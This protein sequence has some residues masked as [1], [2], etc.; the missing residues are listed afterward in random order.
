MTSSAEAENGVSR[1]EDKRTTG[2]GILVVLGG[3]LIHM[4]I[5]TNSSYTF[6]QLGP[7]VT[8][9]IRERSQPED[10]TSQDL[11]L[12]YSVAH[13]V[14]ALMM[15]WAGYMEWHFGVQITTLTGA[16]IL[17]AG[18]LFSF[19]TIQ[20]SFNLVVL[21]SGVIYGVGLGIAYIPAWL[22]VIRWFPSKKG[23][24]IG[25]VVAGFALGSF[26]FGLIEK[27]FIN[28]SNLQPDKPDPENPSQKYYSQPDIL[29]RVPY[30]YLLMAGLFAICQIGGA[31]LI[32]NPP[33]YQRPDL[34]GTPKRDSEPDER[35]PLLQ[36]K[37]NS[38]EEKSIEG[39]ESHSEIICDDE[40]DPKM[41]GK[42]LS[43]KEMLLTRPFWTLWL[44][45]ALVT[46]TQVMVSSL[47]RF[48]G[49]EFID[50]SNYM[51][52]LTICSSIFNAQGR[53]IWGKLAD[54]LSF[55]TVIIAMCSIN[56]IFVLT[57]PLAPAGG[58]VFFFI[59]LCIV[60]FTFTGVFSVI[61]SVTVRVFGV[62][63]SG[64]NYGLVFTATAISSILGAYFDDDIVDALGWGGMFVYCGFCSFLAMIVAFTFNQTTPTGKAI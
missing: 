24:V 23:F 5:G 57:L 42:T 44:V 22:C 59:W 46:Q 14:Q 49:E 6:G 15:F 12:L 52:A 2:R 9:Y 28:P 35:T 17:T 61:P 19:L 43:P 8:S 48:Y 38:I 60:F 54:V 41:S 36:E 25:L 30:A 64:M 16:L 27:F 32:S 58:K 62:K 1:E 63:Y 55:K 4:T 47:Y 26:V 18:M 21:T 40:E 31:L 29:D 20:I 56:A 34:H 7:Y 13:A 37:E 10:L 51:L 11:T 45:Y 3:V 50:D 33:G 39:S 53:I